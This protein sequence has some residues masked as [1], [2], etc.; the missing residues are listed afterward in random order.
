[1]RSGARGARAAL[2]GL[3][4]TAACM[5]GRDPDS[6]AYPIAE[7]SIGMHRIQVEVADTPERMSRGLSGRS[8]LP[9]GRGMLF[10]YARAERHGFWMYD[11]LFDIDIVWIRG[12]RIVDVSP[13]VP[14]D[15]PGEPPVYRPRE[16]ADLVLEVP[17]GTAG[18]LG[19][20]I[21]DQVTMAPPPRS[22]AAG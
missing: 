4:L 17:S 14:H 13:R 1:M 12:D 6:Q 22:P 20:R 18:R 11:M 2:A 10:P 7:V 15:P 16:P 8:G 5:P 9:E 19:W 21:G 3:L